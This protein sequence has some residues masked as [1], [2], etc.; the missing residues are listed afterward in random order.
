MVLRLVDAIR[1]LMVQARAAIGIRNRPSNSKG[2]DIS[3]SS[4]SSNSSKQPKFE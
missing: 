2:F 3:N 4:S 1:I